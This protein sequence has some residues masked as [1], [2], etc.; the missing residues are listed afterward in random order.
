VRRAGLLL[1]LAMAGAGCHDKPVI[2][3]AQAPIE[4]A[5]IS[6]PAGTV[7]MGSTDGDDDERPVHDVAVAAFAM[8]KTEASVSEYARCEAAGACTKTPQEAYCNEGEKAREAHPI[9]CVTYAQATAFCAWAKARL[10]TE[11]EWEYAARAATRRKYPW[12]DAA[13]DAQLLCW[14]G[15][16]SDLGVGK[17]RSTCETGAHPAG[18]SPFG[19]L[20]LAGNVWEWTSDL[21]SRDYNSPRVGPKRVVRGGTWYSYDPADV[22]ATLRFR[23]RED[24]P[25]YGVGFRCAR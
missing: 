18:A 5:M 11:A 17:R 25:D 6:I 24:K 13:P 20:D 12:G 9:N 15:R 16:K 1:P 14:D 23:E 21:Y 22:R 4:L 2:P 8:Q 3:A 19:V 10:P 7:S